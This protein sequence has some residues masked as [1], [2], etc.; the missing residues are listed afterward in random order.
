MSTVWILSQH[1]DSYE[2]GRLLEAFAAKNIDTKLVHPDDFDIIVNRSR[3]KSIR[4]QG[5]SLS[6]IHI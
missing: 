2:N 1:R 5:T 4:Y 3:S 6:L